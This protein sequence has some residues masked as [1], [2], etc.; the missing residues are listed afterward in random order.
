MLGTLQEWLQPKVA[1]TWNGDEQGREADVLWRLQLPHECNPVLEGHSLHGGV[2][3]HPSSQEIPVLG[4][5][6]QGFGGM[7]MI[8]AVLQSIKQ[9]WEGAE[10]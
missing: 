9:G 1:P 6:A 7:H 5:K 4:A 8:A 3:T 10:Q 2:R